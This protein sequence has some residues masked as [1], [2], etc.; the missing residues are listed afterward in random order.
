M[1]KK[2]IEMLRKQRDADRASAE[3][4]LAKQEE[5]TAL[6]DSD[7]K[8]L[9]DLTASATELDVRIK[10]LTELEMSRMAALELDNKFDNA[11]HQFSSVQVKEPERETSF[12]EKFTSS[13]VFTNYMKAGGGTSGV[14]STEMALL[15]TV[16]A[17]TAYLPPVNRVNEPGRPTYTTPL[18][19]AEG[20]EPVNSN[21]IEW[22]EW[23]LAI[24]LASVVAEG[25]P[26]PETA[27]P[28]VLKTANL[29]K[30]AHHI[31]VTREMLE[32]L[33]RVQSIISGVLLQ[34]VRLKAE[35]QAASAL[36]AATLPTAESDTLMKAVRIGIAEVSS[37]GFRPNTVVLNP[38]DYALIDLELLSLTFAGARANQPL[39]GLN[40]VPA[41]I[42][43]EGTAYV[44]DFKTGMTLF[45]RRVTNVYITDSHAAE[46]ISN[47]LRI[48]AEARL[49]SAVVRPEAIVECTAA[50]IP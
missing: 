18:L 2:L 11:V 15:T 16:D 25:A 28:P 44:G 5:G 23:P 39:W 47:I 37:A 10:E 26:K 42:V 21:S 14:F 38:M 20:Y 46:F 7:K 40:V 41:N 8:N 29:I 9:E 4:F 12:G 43:A 48:L 32:D 3:T 13:E 31:P 27:Y 36:V 34:G 49:F 6:T 50:V 19:D 35:E 30:L 33:P 24:P 17:N 45:D 1:S 22:I